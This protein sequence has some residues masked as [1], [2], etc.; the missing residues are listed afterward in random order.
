[1]MKKKTRQ[2]KLTSLSRSSLNSKLEKIKIN[3]AH[4]KKD[5]ANRFVLYLFF[6]ETNP[7]MQKE[8]QAMLLPPAI[9]LSITQGSHGLLIHSR[10]G[11]SSISSLSLRIVDH[12]LGR[13]TGESE[14][15]IVALRS[16]A[17]ELDP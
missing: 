1:M 16:K 4:T 13:L 14:W 15:S 10:A 9:C 2:R 3:C 8:V 7:G 6:T 11:S 12:T 5:R 17:R